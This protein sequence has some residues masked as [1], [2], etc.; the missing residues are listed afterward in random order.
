M[1]QQAIALSLIPDHE[2]QL[3][4]A[5]PSIEGSWRKEWD[6]VVID[7]GTL[8]EASALSGEMLRT[9]ESARIPIVWIENSD[10]AHAPACEQLVVIKEPLDKQALL[11]A[12]AQCVKT[13]TATTDRSASIKREQTQ[14]TSEIP[15]QENK[16]GAAMSQTDPEFIELVDVVDVGAGEKSD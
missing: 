3:R 2:V 8:R 11:S 14:G 5:I 16:T 13:A 12:L 9:L 15:P 10:A 4:D 6:A 7:A 1:L